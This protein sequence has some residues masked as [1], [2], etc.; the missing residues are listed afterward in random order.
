M[1]VLGIFFDE[2]KVCWFILVVIYYLGVVGVI[3]VGCKQFVCYEW[4]QKV[5]YLLGCSLEELFLV[6]FKYQYKGGILQCFIF[7]CQGF[8][9][10]GLGDG[11]GLKLSVLECF[12]G[13]VVGFYSEFFIF[14]VFLV[15]R[16]FKFSQY[17]FCFMMIVDILGF[18]NFEQG[19]LVCGV[20]FEEL[21]YNYI[22]DWL[23]RFF[24]E[25]IFVQ[26]LERYKEENIE[27]VFDDLEFFMED[28]V[29]VVDQVFYQ[30][31][32]CLL[33]CIDEVRG[34][35]WLLEEEVLVLGVSEDIF[36]ECFFFYYGF[37]EGD[38]K[39]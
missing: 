24:C 2:Q 12:E 8:E 26:E 39:G 10:S 14:F 16:V 37:Q 19:G 7:F 11:I 23:Q 15:N 35:F 22:Q 6:I 29:V 27:L 5:V 33:V 36:L 13:M 34:L 9:E 1:K 38:K 31:L 21:C 3:K 4:V 17:L 20:F 30:F 18:Q 32:V 25:C 28:F